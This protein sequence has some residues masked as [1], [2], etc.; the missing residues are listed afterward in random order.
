M[1]QNILILTVVVL[2]AIALFPYLAISSE[3]DISDRELDQP[4][5]IGTVRWSKDF[6]ET[7]LKSGDLKKPVFALFQEVPGCSGCK[8][9]GK[10]VLSEPLIVEAI[11]THFLPVVIYNNRG[12]KDAELLRRFSEPSWNYQVI[13]FFDEKAKDIIPRKDKVWSINGVA[14]RMVEA[15]EVSGSDAP[16]YLQ[17]L[18]L[19]YDS[20]NVGQVLFSQYCFWSGERKLGALDG[21]VGTQAGFYRGHEVPRVWYLKD[22][23]S[24]ENLVDEA[25]RL[26]TADIVYVP[27]A[28]RG[29]FKIKSEDFNRSEYRTAPN[30]DQKKQLQGTAFSK[31]E[32]NNF[33]QTKVNAF[34]RSSRSKALKYLSPRQIERL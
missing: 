23:I 25:V 19:D 20:E 24:V 21:V 12:G 3:A 16:G 13:R 28:E 32:L 30:S 9:F 29:K 4:I 17:G 1:K 8:T 11:E 34:A 10:V 33:Q 15:L 27:K 5:E 7:L 31:L 2:A 18:S 6:D 14:T 26:D 22:K